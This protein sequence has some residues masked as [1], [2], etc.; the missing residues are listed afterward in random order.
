MESIANFK[1]IVNEIRLKN[2]ELTERSFNIEPKITRNIVKMENDNYSVELN[3]SI[4]NTEEKPFPIDL[5][6]SM[7]GNFDL[8]TFPQEQKEDFLNIQAVQ[9]IFPYMRNIISTITTAS[10]M[11]PLVLPI[12]DV[13][14]L[15]Y[16]KENIE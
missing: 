12:V 9:I 7:A 13:N 3:F 16:E 1:L 4:T 6:V 10:F 11:P 8:Q 15:V 14:S 5:F 2:H